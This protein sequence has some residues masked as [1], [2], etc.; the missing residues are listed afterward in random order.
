M[1]TVDPQGV[2]T[3]VT[4]GTAT[5]TVTTDDGGKTAACFV[6]VTNPVIHV[7]S[8]SLNKSTLSL[9]VGSSE[10]LQATVS[11]STASNTDVTWSSSNP[12]VATV[13]SEG[14]INGI[15]EG[16]ATI[17]AECGGFSASCVVDVYDPIRE[18]LNP[19]SY[20]IY[21]ANTVKGYSGDNFHSVDSYMPGLS[22]AVVELKLQ[23]SAP[24]TL[25]SGNMGSS[26]GYY[27][28]IAVSDSE[29]KWNDAY[30]EDGDW[31]NDTDS[32]AIPSATSLLWIKFNG[33]NGTMTI[34]EN[35]SVY[36]SRSTMSFPRLFA[37]YDHESDEGIY[38]TYHGI[39]EGSK[40]Y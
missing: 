22:G 25:T 24:S 13:S 30:K 32:W 40:L 37:T 4:A 18:D 5:I 29:F 19:N 20:L 38:E 16:Y 23:L 34:N 27:D 2:V 33:V 35:V 8:V 39:A 11:P 9:T 3:A 21:R 28:Y 36:T 6:T 12:S 14:V 1:A 26:S 10:T 17:T 7:E 31:W 15:Q